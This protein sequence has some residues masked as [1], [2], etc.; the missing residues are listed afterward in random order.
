MHV[1]RTLICPRPRALAGLVAALALAATGAVVGA[2][3]ASAAAA[4]TLKAAAA[5]TAGY[6]GTALTEAN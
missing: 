5:R 4:T 6:F 3:P 2:A 1:P